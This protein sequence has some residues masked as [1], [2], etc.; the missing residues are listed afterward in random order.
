MVKELT[1]DVLLVDDEEQFLDAF[2]K[3]LKGFGMKVETAPSGDEALKTI[4]GKQYD[5]I[6]LDLVMP[7]LD[8]IQT[9]KKLKEE[10]P[11]MQII[12]LTGH[13]TASKGVEAMK[14]GAVDFMEKPVDMDK[15]LNLIGGAQ[16]KK[17]LLIEKKAEKR[18]KEILASKGW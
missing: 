6:V 7:G 1:A 14:A 16:R 8:G 12:M 3:R 4:K 10:N 13:A 18:I 17:V 11:D 2:S 5:A 15:L 9:L